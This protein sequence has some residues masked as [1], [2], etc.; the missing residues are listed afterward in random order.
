MQT[1]VIQI[2]TFHHADKEKT[3]SCLLEL[4]LWLHHLIT[5]STSS[6][7]NGVTKSPPNSTALSKTKQ[8][9]KDIPNGSQSAILTSEELE[10][11]KQFNKNRR[12]RGISKSQDFDNSITGL[13]KHSRLSKSSSYSPCRGNRELLPFSRFSSGIRVVDFGIDKEKALD[14]IDR[15]DSHR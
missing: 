11:L 15:V 9:P 3:E 1:D 2:E 6:S 5:K 7:K 14:V 13:R 12:I 10:M 8:Q 4:V